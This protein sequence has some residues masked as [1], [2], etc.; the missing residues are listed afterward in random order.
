MSLGKA[1]FQHLA[2][3]P[4]Y[5]ANLP[6]GIEP[7]IGKPFDGV[8]PRAVYAT[9]NADDRAALDGQT[10]YVSE[11]VTVTVWARTKNAAE[12]AAEWIKSKLAS[13]RPSTATTPKVLFWR[14]SGITDSAEVE[15]DGA[16]DTVNAVS[17]NVIGAYRQD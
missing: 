2:A 1:L 15:V 8:M 13:V 9:A 5:L 4:D 3:Q 6:G 16:D 7:D 11:S 17:L 12:A 10:E 14:R